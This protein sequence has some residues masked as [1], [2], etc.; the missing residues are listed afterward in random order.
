MGNLSAIPGLLP[1]EHTQ[2]SL[3]RLPIETLDKMAFWVNDGD[4]VQL[5]PSQINIQYHGDLENPQDK[6]A[7]GGMAWA[8]SVDLREPV[9][10]SMKTNGKY[11]LEDGHHRWFAAKKRGQFLS[12]KVEVKGKPIEA[13]LRKQSRLKRASAGVKHG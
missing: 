2:Q 5:H 12:A 6:F 1:P 8:N 13:I 7:K 9:D 3:E 4:L 11:Y 10:V